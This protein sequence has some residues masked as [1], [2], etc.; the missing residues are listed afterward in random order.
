MSNSTEIPLY[1]SEAGR[2]AEIVRCAR[3]DS[4]IASREAFENEGGCPYCL[5]TPEHR[6]AALHAKEAERRN[7]RDAR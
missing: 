6:I 7:R 5:R 3:D 2:T 1:G 4:H